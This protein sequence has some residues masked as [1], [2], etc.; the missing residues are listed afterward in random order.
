MK[1]RRWHFPKVTVGEQPHQL[2]KRVLSIQVSSKI[3]PSVTLVASIS[4]QMFD[5]ERVG[6]Q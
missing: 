2:D 1:S 4:M 3:L 5:A 6:Q